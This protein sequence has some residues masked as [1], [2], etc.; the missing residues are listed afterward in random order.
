M[1]RR[2]GSTCRRAAWERLRTALEEAAQ[3][4]GV[5]NSRPVKRIRRESSR[6]GVPG[7]YWRTARE[8]ERSVV[9]SAIHP[10]HDAARPRGTA[11]KS[12]PSFRCA[13]K[14]IRSKGDTSPSCTWRSTTAAEFIGVGK[15]RP[16]GTARHRPFGTPCRGGV[17]SGQIWRVFSR[18]GDGDHAPEPIRSVLAPSGGARYRPSSSM[19]PTTSRAAGRPVSRNSWRRS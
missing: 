17:Q 10:A 18:S 6:Q 7:W 15:G 2:A 9:V 13:L 4:A 1:A 14:H 19:R 3:T 11:A 16:Q 8:L 5:V 12:I